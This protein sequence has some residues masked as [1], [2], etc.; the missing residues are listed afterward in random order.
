MRTIS[1]TARRA[2]NAPQT[3]QV[4]LVILE[5][6]HSAL[7][8]PIRVVNNLTSIQ[9]GGNTYQPVAFSFT[10]PNQEDGKAASSKLTIDNV[11][12]QIVQA[13][14]SINSAADVVAKV[15]LFDS[16]DVVE[17]GPLD[18][19]LRNVTY[20]AETVTGDLSFLAYMQDNI[21]TVRYTNLTFPG[22]F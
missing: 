3:D 20:T 4:F 22:L 16:P 8:E 9:H 18:Y 13:V 15:V 17:Y 10:L 19:K 11:D 12:R 5:I 21:G 14:R 1:E 2:V 6:T 7:A